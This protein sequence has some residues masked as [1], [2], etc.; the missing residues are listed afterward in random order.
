[1]STDV[2][3]FRIEIPQRDLDDLHRRLDDAR[4]PDDTTAGD[5]TYGVEPGHLASLVRH[6]RDGFDWR[7]VEEH[8]NTYDQVITEIDGQPV[9]AL[10][11]RSGAPD[12][13]ALLLL[14]G[15]PSTVADFL[16]VLDALR[17]DVHVV[18]PSLPGFGFSGPTLERGWDVDR[19]ATTLLE[20]MRRPGYHRFLVQG[21]DFGSVIAP[22]I[23]RLAPDR[24]LG[25]HLNALVSAAMPDW[26]SPDPLAGLTADERARVAETAAWWPARSGYATIQ[27]TRPQ[28]LAYALTDSPVG[29]LAWNLEWFVDYDPARGVQSPVDPDAV[30]ADVT[31]TWLTGTAGSSARLYKEAAGVFGPPAP[32]SG[33]PTAVACFPGDHAIRTLAERAHHVVRWI[34]YDRGGHFASLQAPDLLVDD[35]RAFTA[36]LGTAAAPVS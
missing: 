26:S 22:Q 12:A 16:P 1:M 35:V 11:A 24:V 17:R 3:P 14:H 33:V 15:W 27:G 9:H 34:T 28:T 6:W 13:P 8:L 29:L 32:P 19:H 10:H 4:L 30:L 18:A 20:L 31:I 25:V 36:T 7:A 23:G 5:W 21:G 2:R